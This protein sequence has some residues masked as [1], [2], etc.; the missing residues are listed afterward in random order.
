MRNWLSGLILAVAAVSCSPAFAAEHSIGDPVV[1]DGMIIHPVYLQP[2]DMAP[3]LP[4]MDQ[5]PFDAHLEVDI[6]ADKNNAQGFD[7]GSW[8]PYLTVSYQVVKEGTDWST[9]GTM[10][11]MT[12]NDGPHY[13]VNVKFNG[14]GK[15]RVSLKILPPPYIGFSR[16]TDKETGVPE[17][18]APIEKSWSFVYVGTGHKGAY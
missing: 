6:H 13:G 1:V 2:V 14:P 3:M 15:Y 12:A 11:A 17:W 7:P 9:F 5:G 8:I 4:G 18:W 10:M 16:H